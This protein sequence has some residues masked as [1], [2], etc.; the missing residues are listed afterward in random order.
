MDEWPRRL[1]AQ[2]WSYPALSVLLR[3][4]PGQGIV[5][6]DNDYRSSKPF[7]PSCGTLPRLEGF[8]WR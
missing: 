7:D 8:T 1:F 3:S 5:L 4:A 2:S 6:I